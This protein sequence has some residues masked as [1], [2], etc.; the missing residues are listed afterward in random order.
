MKVTSN[1]L[2][3]FGPAELTDTMILLIPPPYVRVH[4]V[5]M[6]SLLIIFYARIWGNS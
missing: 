6:M 2:V 1:L 5:L 3:L 4:V